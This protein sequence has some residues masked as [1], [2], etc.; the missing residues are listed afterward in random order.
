MSNLL[1]INDY[2]TARR[3]TNSRSVKWR[4]GQLAD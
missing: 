3:Q 1:A 4:T 2:R